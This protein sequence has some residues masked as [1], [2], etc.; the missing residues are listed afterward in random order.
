MTR[1]LARLS[2]L[3]I[4]ACVSTVAEAACSEGQ[5]VRLYEKGITVTKI[6][7]RCEMNV[8]DVADIVAK[9]GDEEPEDPD[10]TPAQTPPQALPPAPPRQAMCCDAG[11][12][13][14]CPV[15]YGDTTI[16]TACF[17]PGQGYG[18]IC[19]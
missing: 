8:D 16:G 19:R 14:R 9:R 2:V 12:Y 15:L 17:C 7:D 11:G 4:M 13:S 5:I 1:M 18:V 6:A 3:I 10:P